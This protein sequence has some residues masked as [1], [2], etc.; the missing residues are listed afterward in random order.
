MF[1]FIVQYQRSH[2]LCPWLSTVYLNKDLMEM[3]DDRSRA[4]IFTSFAEA[5]ERG[6]YFHAERFNEHE[7]TCWE[8]SIIPMRY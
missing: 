8:P 4:S 3:V 6:F 2:W 7:Q 5:L 1:Y